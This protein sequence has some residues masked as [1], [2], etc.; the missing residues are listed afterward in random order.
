M[1]AMLSLLLYGLLLSVNSAF[2]ASAQQEQSI[3][4]LEKVNL[5]LKWL[6]QFQFAG[7]YAAK[8]LGY[9]AQAGLDVQIFERSPNK[10][11][12]EQVVSGERDY[13]VGDCAILSYYARGEPIAALAAIFQHN[14]SVFISKKSSGIISP[15]EMKGKRIMFDGV[16]E[17]DSALRAVLA[18]TQLSEKNYS[19]IQQSFRNDDLTDNKVDVMSAYLSNEVFYFQQK[20]IAIN[21]INPQNY[22]IDFYG[23]M[24]FTSQRELLQHHARAEKFRAASL[25]GWQYALAHSEQLIQLIHNKYHSKLSL[26]HLRFEAE[27]IRKLI[28]PDVIPLGQIEAGRLRKVAE[29]YVQLGISKPLSEKKLAQFINSSTRDDNKPLIVGSEQDFPPFALGKTD[30]TASGFTVELW[31]AV[32]AESHLQATIRVL[33]F[34]DIL[35]QFKDEKIDVLINLAQSDERRQFADFTVPH[36]IVNGAFFVRDDDNSISSLADVNAKQL[37]VVNADLA[38]DYAIA[39]GWEK[40]L[41]RADNAQ[42]GLQWLAQG[43]YDAML[44][45]KLTG[46]QTLDKLKLRHIKMLPIQVDFAQKFSFAVHKGDAEL[47]AKINE[48]LAL[49]KANGTYDKLYEKWFGV[50]ED[51]APQSRLLE[52]LI[53]IVLLFLAILLVVFYRR[54]I[55]HEQAQK[56]IAQRERH[57][58]AILNASTSCI[59]LVAR[60]GT[61]L[62]MNPSGLSAI[63]ADSEQQVQHHCVYNLLSP[64]YRA[65]YQAFNEAVCDGTAGFIQFEIITL[66]NEKRWMETNAVPFILETGEVVQLAFAQEI[67]A[68]KQA[69]MELQ[70]AATVFEC[71][72]G[73]FITNTQGKIL[74]VNE[75]FTTITGY[76]QAEVIGKNPRFLKSGRQDKAF[77]KQRWQRIHETGVWQGEIWNKRKNGE[78][79]PQWQ[80]ITAV[81]A[82]KDHVISH[83]V[84]TLNDITQRK[85]AEETIRQLAFYDALTGLANRRLFQERLKHGIDIDNRLHSKKQLALLMLD[86]DKFKAVND[87]FGHKAGDELLQQ[88]ARRISSGMREVD[89]LARLGGDEFIV[90]LENISHAE[91]ASRLA[92]Q[93]IAT[94][95][96]PFTLSQADNVQIGV[97]IGISL[98]PQ[99]GTSPEQLIDYADAALYHAK[100]SGRGCFAYFSDE[101]TQKARARLALESRLRQA[102]AQNQL[103]VYFQAQV[104][105]ATGQLIGA[106]ALVRWQDAIKGLIMPS[107][108]I[109]IAEDTGLIAAIGEWVLRETCRLGRQWLDEGLPPISLAVN[110]SAYQFHRCDLKALVIEVLAETGFPAHLLELEIT[111]TGLLEN[112]QNAMSTLNALHQLGIHLAIDDFGTGYSSL[113]YLKFLPLDVLK[114][115][116]SFIDD[117]PFLQSDMTITAT[118]I[119]MAHHLGFK[120]LAEG[121]ETAEQ[122]AFLQKH[123]C[124]SYQGYLYSKP[125]PASDFSE[126]LKGIT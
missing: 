33:S 116:K 34:H 81:K 120:V 25:K 51:K 111:E 100:E 101:L 16:G 87:N 8:E 50:Y 39:K 30:A 98:Y 94:L 19:A 47:L 40:Q 90:L 108:F 114:I 57:L 21:I 85:A 118:I 58:R 103:R 54:R 49:V 55:E 59:K 36:V 45:S 60:D 106:E 41:V 56:Q 37:I 102:I 15:Y 62:S 31:R 122:L 83:Y 53:P 23:D 48:G 67:T 91:D 61:L 9:Y 110:I 6:H 72:E 84:T 74:K 10:D 66:N 35:Q 117:I 82:N 99:H 69:E 2:S 18:E 88:V 77:Y 24:L 17:G 109:S 79:Y 68:R 28:L 14:P 29:T 121:V 32:A 96:K 11:V 5:Q 104:D 43:R 7:Y 4:P 89:T 125:L 105:V 46:R 71:Q 115:D 44:L 119:A 20:K 76:S 97:S 107:E 13:A 80:T 26:A 27:M 75:A 113:A 124:D 52:V 3:A 126:L 38:Q 1:K 78:I 22:G 63:G 64:E 93:I 65:A 12:V 95:S 70:I 92:E 86:L 73:V 112:Q 42:T 123:G